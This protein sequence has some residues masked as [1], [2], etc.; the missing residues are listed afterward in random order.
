MSSIEHEALFDSL[1][2]EAVLDA[3]AIDRELS[4]DES[5]EIWDLVEVEG[6]KDAAARKFGDSHFLLKSLAAE[7]SELSN[8]GEDFFVDE[9]RLQGDSL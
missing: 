3:D 5:G 1:V 7:G 9:N 8:I 4:T 2:E 6:H